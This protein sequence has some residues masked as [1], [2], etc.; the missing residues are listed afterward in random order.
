MRSCYAHAT[1]MLRYA[2][3]HVHGRKLGRCCVGTPC[4]RLLLRT[5]RQPPPGQA[6]RHVAVCGSGVSAKEA[7]VEARAAP[8][9]E[10]VA[11][12][13]AEEG[14]ATWIC[15]AGAGTAR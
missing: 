9:V 13:E 10:V 15:P 2:H 12:V 14:D 3:A 6:T 4:S 5:S 8:F 11:V 7:V 1:L